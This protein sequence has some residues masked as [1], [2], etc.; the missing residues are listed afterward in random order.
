MLP[1]SF[2][3]YAK[4]QVQAAIADHGLGDTKAKQ[5]ASEFRHW[6]DDVSGMGRFSGSLD[7][8]RYE[9]L[10]NAIDQRVAS[11]AASSEETVVKNSNLAA[12][13]LVELATAV[14][15]EGGGRRP[16]ASVLVVVDHETVTN[17]SHPKSIRR[18]ESGHDISPE[19]IARLCCDAVIRRVTHDEASVPIDVGR[20][21]RTA[22]DGQWAAIK[23]MHVACAWDGCSA[24]IQ[25]CQAHHIHEWEQGGST[26]FAV[27]LRLT[28]Q[29]RL[30]RT[31]KRTK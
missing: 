24:P 21:Y 12:Q 11:I 1:E 25:W 23:S 9:A 22:T 5:A 2:D 31:W 13:A 26:N 16:L 3:R 27:R 29:V 17:G 20:K 28:K 8:E 15:L 14:G 6:F 4:S 18:T 30:R 19:S 10:T 7:P